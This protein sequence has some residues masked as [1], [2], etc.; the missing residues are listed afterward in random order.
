VPSAWIVQPFNLA[1]RDRVDSYVHFND[2]A[3]RFFY[4]RKILM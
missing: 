1:M 2:H 4:L 3:V